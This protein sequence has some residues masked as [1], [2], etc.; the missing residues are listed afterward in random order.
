MVKM[1]TFMLYVFYHNKNKFL[2]SESG[3]VL[4]QV[5]RDL[6]VSALVLLEHGPRTKDPQHQSSL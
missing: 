1:V 3:Q 2:K 4:R 5:L 6:E